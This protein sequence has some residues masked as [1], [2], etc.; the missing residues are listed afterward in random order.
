MTVL[1]MA[2]AFLP[3]RGWLLMARVHSQE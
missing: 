1:T 2:Q 3:V